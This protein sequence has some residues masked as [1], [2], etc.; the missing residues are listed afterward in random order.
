[1]VEVPWIKKKKEKSENLNQRDHNTKEESELLEFAQE[2]FQ[3][4]KWNKNDYAGNP[5]HQK[6]SRVDKIYRGDQWL[7]PIPEGK[8][9]PVLN[10]TFALVEALI[11]RMTDHRPDIEVYARTDPQGTNLAEMLANVQNYLWYS[12][13]MDQKMPEAVRMAIKY[14]TAIFK[15]IWDTDALNGLGDVKYSVIH[16]MN[17]FPDPRAYEVDQME[18]CFISIP[19][20]LEFFK[21]R[22][23]DKG[24]LIEADMGWQDTEAVGDISGASPEKTAPLVEFWFYDEEENLCVMYYCQ[25]LVLEVI[26]GIYSNDSNP[27]PIYP[28]NQMPFAKFV[29]Y[30]ADKEF[31]GIGEVEIVEMLQRLINSFES[32]IIDNTRL[33]SNAIWMVNKSLSGMTEE[34]AW[35]LDN[36]PGTAIF[37][38]NGGVERVPGEPIPPHVNEHVQSLVYAM[39]QIL[40]IHDVVQGRSPSGGVRAASAII[41]LQESANIRV[42]QKSNNMAYALEDMSRLANWLILDNYD[43]QRN[44]RIAGTST[45]TTLNV[46]EALDRRMIDRA[47]QAGLQDELVMP[48][49]SAGAM[50]EDLVQPDFTAGLAPGPAAPGMPTD[51]MAGQGMMDTGMMEPGMEGGM[52]EPGMEGGMMEPGMEGGIEGMQ[53]Q[54]PEGAPET[55]EE[56]MERIYEY[57]AF[58]EFDVEVKVGPSVPYSQALRYE[59]AKELYQLGIIDR[60]AVLEATNFPGKEE[61]L[62]RMGEYDMID[63][64]GEEGLGERM[65]EMTFGGAGDVPGGI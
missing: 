2:R 50:P 16:P 24:H 37:T 33:M 27:K 59:E 34:D 51:L 56:A 62:Q 12:N 29:D 49:L 45:P 58:P 65:G 18:Y 4:A 11:P 38:H 35:M 55:E 5:L 13:R 14:G 63:A 42:K 22:W 30:P 25:D 64:E 26:G 21:Y 54:L 39:E 9:A 3:V 31:W 53:M 7:E 41:A 6:W 15:V 40:G 8:S 32:Q 28:H 60:K 20:S 61:I 57:V 19:K 44:V 47:A 36:R 17:F 43:E 48:N 52:M 1:M 23:P 10:Y 46:R